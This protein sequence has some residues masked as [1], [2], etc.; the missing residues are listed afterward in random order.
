M[1]LEGQAAPQFRL[2]GSDG[3]THSLADWAGKTLVLFFYPKDSTPGCTS[4]AVG[5]RDLHP[6]FEQLG[7]AVVGLSKDSLKSHAKFSETYQL[8]YPLL[9]DPDTSVLAA[10]GAFGEKVMYGKKTVGTIRSTVVI[11]P[12]GTVLKHWA[13]VAKASEHP[14]QVLEFLTGLTRG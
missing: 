1:S 12:E 14:T 5:F 10:Y 13:K 8:P 2:E 4:E 7:A 11:S 9:S 6:Q 3:K